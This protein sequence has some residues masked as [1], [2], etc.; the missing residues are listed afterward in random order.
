MAL[1]QRLNLKQTLQLRMTP[2]LRQAIK[3]LQV[4]RA[5]LETMI[6]EELCQNPTL[7][8]FDPEAVAEEA[9]L[10][11]G[12]PV[13]SETEPV[14]VSDDKPQTEALDLNEVDWQDYL[15]RFGHEFHGS[16]GTGSDRDDNRISFIE[17][18]AASRD[19]LVSSLEDQL[20]LIAM[21]D[22]E[23]RVAE[24][25]IHNLDENGYLACTPEEIAFMANCSLELVA[26]ARE[27]V[28]ELEPPGVGSL[29]L[30]ECLLVQLRLI[31]YEPDDYVVQIVD[32]H[33]GDL[34]SRRY[35]KIAKALGTTVDE[36]LECHRIIQGLEPKPGRNFD[37]GST[38]YIVPDVYIQRVGDDFQVILNDEGLPSLRINETYRR[39]LENGADGDETRGYLQEK[40]RSAQ[41][42]IRS[43]HQR[44]R[45]LYKVTK[46]IV[47]HQREFLLHGVEYLKP[48]VLKDIANDIGMHESTVSRATANKYVHTPQGIFELK[49]FFT[50]S[51]RSAD[52]GSVSSESVKQKIQQIIA[53]EDP[54][55]PFSD[56]YIADVL[57]KENIDIAR[58]TVAKYRELL[59]ILPSSK[60]KRM[61]ART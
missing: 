61:A 49:Y 36:V 32:R 55:K 44:Q 33:L 11:T 50:S 7:E 23:R 5:E 43:I 22:D 25:I 60:R 6:S 47:E 27:I 45:T 24:I 59:G 39:M 12:D 26:D 16:I 40:L 17:N 58:R 9:E 48:M 18:T 1:E 51:I 28:Q 38:R 2:Q 4:S 14:E 29:D 20:H 35:E 56:Q 15:D 19:D 37:D 46:S 13:K 54:A 3:I 8:E 21:S 30:R 31:G 10:R 42:L 34:E 41:W 57:A 53:R 52:G